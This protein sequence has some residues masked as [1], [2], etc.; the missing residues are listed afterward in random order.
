MEDI[1][2]LLLC[3]HTNLLLQNGFTIGVIALQRPRSIIHAFPVSAPCEKR[4]KSTVEKT[5]KLQQC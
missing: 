2:G 5:T 3:R 4:V 1:A